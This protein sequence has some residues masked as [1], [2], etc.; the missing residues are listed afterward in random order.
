MCELMSRLTRDHM[1]ARSRHRD[2]PNTA[3]N[4]SNC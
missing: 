3:L 1:V 2:T 4:V